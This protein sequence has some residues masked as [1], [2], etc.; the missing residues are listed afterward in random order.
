MANWVTVQKLTLEVNN[1]QQS[2]IHI[3][4]NVQFIFQLINIQQQ[5]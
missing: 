1:D 4:Q 5:I 3:Y 2:V